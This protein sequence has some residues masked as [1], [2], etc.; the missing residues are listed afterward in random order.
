LT[1]DE[2]MNELREQFH[3]TRLHWRISVDPDVI[4][5]VLGYGEQDGKPP[6][7]HKEPVDV[8]EFLRSLD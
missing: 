8:R 7:T 5:G 6:R 1:R 3:K 2:A 4:A